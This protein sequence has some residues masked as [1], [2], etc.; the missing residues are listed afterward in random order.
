MTLL[1]LFELK[2]LQ[3]M[4]SGNTCTV[5]VLSF[6]KVGLSLKLF[7]TLFYTSTLSLLPRI[8]FNCRAFTANGKEREKKERICKYRTTM[9]VL[10]LQD[11]WA[12]S[13]RGA[14]PVKVTEEVIINMSLL[15]HS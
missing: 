1:N 14:G 12:H 3:I 4:F 5:L 8:A 13:R 7:E 2:I 10:I 9:S 15:G 11:F 6:H